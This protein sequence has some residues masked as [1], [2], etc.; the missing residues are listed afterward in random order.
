[1]DAL[2]LAFRLGLGLLLVGGGVAKY[3]RLRDF[4]H[5]VADYKILPDRLISAVAWTV[6]ALEL[7]MGLSFLVGVTTGVA[8]VAAAG[9]F[10]A[11]GIAM[12]INLFRGRSINCGC[13][14]VAPETPIRWWLVGRNVIFAAMALGVAAVPLRPQDFGQVVPV[15]VATVLMLSLVALVQAASRALAVTR[16]LDL[17][18]GRP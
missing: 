6:P 9:L 12:S 7:L 8:G 4:R 3:L 11:F 5:A 13:L 15:A 1:M 16:R 14:G 17:R 2:I 18:L 10:V